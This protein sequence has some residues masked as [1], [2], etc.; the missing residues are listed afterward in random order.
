MTKVLVEKGVEGR[1]QALWTALATTVRDA[2]HAA[3]EARMFK[4]AAMDAAEECVFEAA[5]RIKQRPL[6]AVGA[7][8]VLGIPAGIAVGWMLSR[9]RAR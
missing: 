1:T 3:H 7:A 2:R 5:H 6:A 4:T 9:P 8:F